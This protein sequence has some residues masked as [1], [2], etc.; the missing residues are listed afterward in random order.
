MCTT[1]QDETQVV[2]NPL[3]QGLSLSPDFMSYEKR[4]RHAN[5]VFKKV[6]FLVICT[7]AVDCSSDVIVEVTW[8]TQ[9][10]LIQ[11][12]RARMYDLQCIATLYSI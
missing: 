4:E 6:G 5:Y 11:V 12:S 2:F 3:Y 8:H 1:V 10:L 7:G 9:G